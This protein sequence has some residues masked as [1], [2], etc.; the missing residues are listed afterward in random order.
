MSLK[1]NQAT[2]ISVA[3][4]VNF[5]QEFVY[6]NMDFYNKSENGSLSVVRSQNGKISKQKNV[7]MDKSKN[8]NKSERE[9]FKIKNRQ[10]GKK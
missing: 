7:R 6:P 10:N 5:W 2:R 1:F 8:R 3:R 9:S 4:K